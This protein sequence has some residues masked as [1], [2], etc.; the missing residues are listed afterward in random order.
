MISGINNDSHQDIKDML[1]LT[2]LENR[3]N[4]YPSEI[5]GGE[6]QRIAVMR[7]LVNRPSIVLADEPTGNLD[8]ENSQILLKIMVDLKVKYQ[9]SFIITTHEI[10]SSSLLVR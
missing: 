10:A 1:K 7:A 4:H 8:R 6:R 9:Q 3:K 2:N 5:S